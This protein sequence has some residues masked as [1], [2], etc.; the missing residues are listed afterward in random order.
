MVGTPLN[1]DQMKKIIKHMSTMKAPW[2]CPHGRPTMRHLVDLN[3]LPG[4]AKPAPKKSKQ[5]TAFPI[6]PSSDSTGSDS[7]DEDEDFMLGR[8]K[9]KRDPME[10]SDDDLR[11][12][13]K[14]RKRL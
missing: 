14:R 3:F 1:K 8:N 12:N 7:M 5:K 2:N 11:D 10:D 4:M 13:S 6:R 9:R